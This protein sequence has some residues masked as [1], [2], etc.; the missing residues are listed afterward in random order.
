MKTET[1][2]TI[3]D[4]FLIILIFIGIFFRF[5]NMNWDS[6]ALLHPDEYGFTNTISRLS[7]PT[8]IGNYFNTRE[9]TLSPYNKYDLAGEKTADGP[10]NRMRWG[11]LPIL[12]IRLTSEALGTTGYNEI[13]RT[14]RYLSALFDVGTLLI[15]FLMTMRLLKNRTIAL[16][17]T[18]LSS[19]AVMQIQQSHFM[20]SDSFAVF[21]LTLTLYASVR[22]A[23]TQ[24]LEKATENS[25]YR[26]TRSGWTW[27][28]L[29]GVFLGMATASK[30]NQ[31][32][33]GAMVVI[34]VFISVADLKL[35]SKRD[36]NRVFWLAFGM[37]VFSAVCALVT[38]RIFQP[39]SFRAT[40]GDTNLFTL[41]F[42]PD[43]SDSMLVSIAESS[44]I[45][46]GPPS[47]QWAHRTPVLF[48]WIN[49]LLYGMGIPLGITAWAAVFYACWRI[50]RS[51]A[52]EWKVLLIP[53]FW[54]LFYFLYMGTRFVKSIRYM[55]PVYPTL[56]LLAAWGLTVLWQRFQ[57]KKRLFPAI[58]CVIVLGG[59]L[60]WAKTFV[61]TIYGQPH[62]RVEAVEWIYDSIPAMIQ[63][64]GSLEGTSEMAKIIPSAPAA[65]T[66]S[67]SAPYEGTIQVNNNT[68]INL[69]R[70]PHVSNQTAVDSLLLI[71]L[72]DPEDQILSQ[73]EIILKANDGDQALNLTLPSALLTAGTGYRIRLSVPLGSDLT[74]R[75]NVLANENWD[76]G[77]PFPYQGYDPFGQLYTGITNEVRWSDSESKKEMLLN[78]LDQADYIMLPSQRSIWSAVRI[79][80]TYPMTIDYYNALFDGSLGFE[81][82]AQF[83]H[84]FQFGSLY[85]SDLTGAFRWGAE[86]ELPIKNLNPWAAEEA[87]SVYDHP[88]VW[89]FKKTA[90]FD[91]AAAKTVLD[92]ADLSKVVVQGPTNATWPEGYAE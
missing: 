29:F 25:P 59:T 53:T 8:S 51:K 14:G 41:K 80:L 87:F 44:G 71:E 90:D 49:M 52:G 50:I 75:R 22:I 35:T 86:P 92:R 82:A 6:G 39:M 15:L 18:A 84:P 69:I 40:S 36:W 85:F 83:Q 38:F 61:G 24:I 32:M 4:I 70:L 55:L 56:C 79:P 5:F 3:T 42:N 62:T 63:L 89:I 66:I 10:D 43:W 74:L 54:S 19:L 45:G 9:S 13:R 17:A 47:E 2:K 68:L 78:T 88:P 34:A 26:V 31:A 91:L 37:C 20:T 73:T 48:P 30:I 64:E 11:Q 77:L 57:G 58:V 60:T 72:L 7:V 76:E 1:K 81:L 46:G 33:T 28:A 21:F 16:L 65:L 12:I 23:Q 67:A 27:F